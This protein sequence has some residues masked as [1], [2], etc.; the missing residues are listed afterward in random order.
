MTQIDFYILPSPALDARLDFACKLTEK[1][2]RLGHRV[3]VRC[4][5][6]A[7][8]AALDARLWDFKGESFIPHSLAEEHAD[9]PIA[10]ALGDEPGLHD[11]LLINLGA[12]IQPAFAGFAR[13]AE[14]VLDDPAS[15]QAARE[16]FRFYRDK[17][18][19][20]QDHRLTRL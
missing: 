10:L 19:P 16:C 9:A 3:Y 14:I 7:Q 11:D 17:G 12:G 1:A 8:R 18:Y 20:L 6:S 2:W 15:R 4:G 5:D 13:L